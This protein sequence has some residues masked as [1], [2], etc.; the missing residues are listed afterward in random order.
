MLKKANQWFSIWLLD[1]LF[2]CFGDC[3]LQI[4]PFLPVTILHSHLISHIVL[5]FN[6]FSAI[7][8]IIIFSFS[9][10]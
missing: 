6:L 10:S 1:V 9:S 8:I 5:E 3:P 7:H 4:G 2:V